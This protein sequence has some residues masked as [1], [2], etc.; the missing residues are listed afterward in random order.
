MLWR[1]NVTH[2]IMVEVLKTSTQSQTREVAMSFS[3]PN[4]FSVCVSGIVFFNV[5][6]FLCLFKR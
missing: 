4:S 6:W 5:I 2:L 3:D 1:R